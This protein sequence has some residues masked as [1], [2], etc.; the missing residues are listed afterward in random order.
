[1]YKRQQL[2]GVLADLHFAPTKNAA[3]HLLSEGKYSESVVVT[4]NTAI[5]AMKYTVD[6]NYK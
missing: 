3:S 6:D 5:D 4:G 2:V 1:M